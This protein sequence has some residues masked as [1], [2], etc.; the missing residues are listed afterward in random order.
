MDPNTSILQLYLGDDNCISLNDSIERNG[1]WDTHEYHDTAD[2]RKKKEAKAFTFYRMETEDISERYDA[3]CFVNGLEVYDG[4]I[5]LEHDKNLISNEFAVKLC[6]EHEE[7]DIEPGLVL[8]RSLLRLTKGIVNFGNGIITIYPDLDPFN[9]VD[10][11]KT[12]DSEDDW[13]VI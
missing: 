10:F 9:D 1:E 4:E 5:N 8:G 6:L 7:D 11:D 3:P 12:N 13:E 2:S